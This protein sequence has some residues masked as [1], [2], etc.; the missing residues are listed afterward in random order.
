M[1]YALLMSRF[2]PFL[3]KIFW[4]LEQTPQTF[5]PF[6][7]YADGSSSENCWRP[8]LIL[9]R[10]GFLFCTALSLLVEKQRW[11]VLFSSFM[12]GAGFIGEPQPLRGGSL[13]II[14]FHLTPSLLLR[15]VNC[16]IKIFHVLKIA[17]SDKAACHC[18]S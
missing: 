15:L 8:S 10:L 5:S 13:Y 9:R 2:T 3:R 6:W 18:I 12:E 1:I 4:T 7:M 11:P 14:D 16:A 17:T